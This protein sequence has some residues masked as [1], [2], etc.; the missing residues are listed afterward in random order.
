MIIKVTRFDGQCSYIFLSLLFH[1]LADLLN[2]NCDDIKMSSCSGSHILRFQS[3]QLPPVWSCGPLVCV[4][5]D[6]QDGYWS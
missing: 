4:S 5:F 1:V 2:P 6:S 3:S